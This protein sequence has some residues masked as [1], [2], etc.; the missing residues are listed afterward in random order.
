MILNKYIMKMKGVSRDGGA[1]SYTKKSS[2]I[3]NDIATRCT[4]HQGWGKHRN[5]SEA[6]SIDGTQ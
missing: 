1:K 6:M 3:E 5:D 2:I 4:L